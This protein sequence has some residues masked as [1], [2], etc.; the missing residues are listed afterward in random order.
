V[1]VIRVKAAIA[2]HS[3]VL[4]ALKSHASDHAETAEIQAVHHVPGSDTLDQVE[5]VVVAKLRRSLGAA[6][7]R[8][9]IKQAKV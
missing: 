9:R 4:C 2:R 1:R 7:T 5:V 8:D 3:I 6:G